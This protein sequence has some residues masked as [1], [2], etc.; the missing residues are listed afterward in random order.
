VTAPPA[1]GGPGRPAGPDGPGGAAAGLGERA[2][3]ARALGPAPGSQRG[4]GAWMAGRSVERAL[5]FKG[6]GLRLL[7]MLRPQRPLIVGALLL[8]TSSV[9][10][11]V[12]G[13]K[14]LGHA[15]D[16]IFTGVVA[17]DLPA[18]TTKAEEV[19][20]LRAEGQ[21]TRADL[22]A[23]LDLTPGAGIPFDRVRDVLLVVLAIYL[24]SA[25]LGVFQGRLTTAL[26]QR[27]VFDLREVAQAKLARLPLSYFDRQPRG[28]LLSRVTNDIDNLQQSLA[29]TLSQIVTSLLTIIGVLAMM[30]YIS[31]LLAL[32]ALVTVPVS[33][34]VAARIGKLAQPNFVRP[35]GSTPTSRRCTAA[36]RWSRSSG[37]RERPRR[38]SPSRTSGS[39][40]R[41]SG[42][43]SSPA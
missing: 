36:T 21:D 28:E 19:A 34:W 35:A 4:P 31:P 33:I 24:V 17:R 1:Q 5:D 6:S 13:P 20:R 9:V 22:L 39:T 41:A 27:A 8:G 30:I 32:I 10:L 23:S 12:I 2:T 38:R 37:G 11:S 42:R 16:L 18:G 29:Q 43:S 40:R 26:V 3:P 25:V 15:T 14:V 7:R